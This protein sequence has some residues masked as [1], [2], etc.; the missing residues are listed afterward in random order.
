M[1]R[2]EADVSDLKA[3]ARAVRREIVLSVAHAGGGHI[4]GPMSA[5]EIL[6]ALYFRVLRI[7]PEE[8]A[9]VAEDVEG[10]LRVQGR[11]KG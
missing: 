2:A 8:P 10:L 7:R 6:T 1:I 5:V 4:G 9:R 11:Q 3:T